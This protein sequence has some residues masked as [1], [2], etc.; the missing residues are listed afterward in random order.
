MFSSEI[1]IAY[2]VVVCGYN[3][4][5]YGILKSISKN[6]DFDRTLVVDFNPEVIRYL[7][8]TNMPCIYGDAGDSEI[9]E[10][11][12]LK[13][14]KMLIST[15]PTMST[16]YLLLHK[17]REIN[18]KAFVIV[19]AGQVDEALK[20][21]NHGAD[22]VIMP[23]LIGGDH[24]GNIIQKVNNGTLNLKAHKSKIIHDLKE[25]Q[26]LGHEMSIRFN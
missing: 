17:F 14:I 18:K 11:I 26:S 21:Y 24:V 1:I 19:T 23:H 15:I 8:G 7:I 16:N 12:N 5:G 3:R 4:I 20:L 22:Y 2:D 6:T 13:T 9:L 25:R 10:R